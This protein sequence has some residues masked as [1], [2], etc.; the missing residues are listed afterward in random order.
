LV[1]LAFWGLCWGVT[2]MLLAVPLTATLKIVWENMAFT[3]PLAILMAEGEMTS[4]SR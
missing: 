1:S 3:R 2:G 4:W